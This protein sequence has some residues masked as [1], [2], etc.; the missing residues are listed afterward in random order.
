MMMLSPAATRSPERLET[1]GASLRRK[2][3]RRDRDVRRAAQSELP[4]APRLPH[5]NRGAVVWNDGTQGIQD[6]FQ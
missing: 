6:D 5:D 2:V 4:D 3:I 1:A